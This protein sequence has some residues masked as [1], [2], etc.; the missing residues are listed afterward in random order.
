MQIMQNMQNIEK[1][2]YKLKEPAKSVLASIPDLSIAR[3][4]NYQLYDITSKE[5]F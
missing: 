2:T 5:L 1:K 3:F 4:N